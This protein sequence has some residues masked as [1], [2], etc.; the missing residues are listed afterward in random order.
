MFLAISRFRLRRR[1]IQ[2]VLGLV[3]FG[4]GIGLMLDSDLGLPP[5]DVLHQG[6]AE[7]IGGTV[8]LWSIVVS[9]V[10]LLLWFPL[11][12][13]FG[14]GTLLNFAIIGVA[15]DLT[16]AL[17]PDPGATWVRW[18]LLLGGIYLIGVSSGMYIG[19]N[20]GPGPRDGLMTGISKRGPS[21]RLTRFALEAIVLGVGWLLGGTFGLG[22]VIFAI[23]IGPIVHYYLPRWTIDTDSAREDP[24][25][26]VHPAF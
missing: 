2:L 26:W 3:L 15:I 16:A 24:D 22:T 17:V 8:G 25:A 7:R 23:A 18:A 4:V 9:I 21:I 19:A 11:R 1:L 12:E 10:V 5:W 14:L 20:L 13:P 6:L